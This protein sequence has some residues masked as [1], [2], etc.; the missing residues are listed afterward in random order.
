MISDRGVEVL[1]AIV[2]DYI[3]TNQPVGSKSLV[4][5]HAFGVSA[6]TIRNDMAILEEEELI[7]QTHTSSGRVPTDK[8]YR[9]FVDR[10]NEVKPLTVAE[11]TAME[12]LLSGSADLD[13]ILGRTVR[14]LAQIT[15]QVAMVQYPTLGKSKVSNV[16]IVPVTAS[17]VL[18]ILVADSGRHEERVLELGRQIDQDFIAE[19]RAKLSAT[20]VGVALSDVDSKLT[21]FLKSFS[22]TRTAE[23]QIVLDGLFEQIDANRTEKLL[24]AG[25]ANLVRSE[26][27]FQGSISPLLEAMEE[28]VVLLKLISEMQADESGVSLRIG[29]ENEFEG[30]N[31]A[32]LLV[33]GYENQGSEVAKIGVLGPTRMDYSGNIAAVRAIARYLTQTLGA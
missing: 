4:D 20:I 19:L 7:T 14:L 23:V 3:S 31:Q 30:L 29:R 10:L 33:S 21:N 27:D 12:T 16:E 24:L 25:T 8:G 6:A 1:R 11:R 15:K 26:G 32:T 5:R 17:R 18:L 28:Q 2:Q 13:E 9:L 22:S